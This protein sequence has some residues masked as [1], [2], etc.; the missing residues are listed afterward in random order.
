MSECVAFTKDFIPQYLAAGAAFSGDD[1]LPS[2]T[3]DERTRVSDQTPALASAAGGWLSGNQ[4]HVLPGADGM[5]GCSI[6][7]TLTAC[8]A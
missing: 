5:V 6:Q 2:R 8:I 4:R 1:I 7:E 3:A